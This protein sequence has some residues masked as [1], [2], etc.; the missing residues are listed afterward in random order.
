MTTT[1]L[2]SSGKPESGPE[3]QETVNAA[4]MAQNM[5]KFLFMG[6]SSDFQRLSFPFSGMD[7]IHRMRFIDKV[8]E[9]FLPVN[10]FRC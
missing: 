3:P 8:K 9:I 4:H 5:G 1:G 6:R 7:I 2:G 10:E